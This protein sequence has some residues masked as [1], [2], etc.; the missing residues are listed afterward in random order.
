MG[1]Q[2]QY[3]LGKIKR[4]A[5]ASLLSTSWE[6]KAFYLKHD[7]SQEIDVRSDGIYLKYQKLLVPK[8]KFEFVLDAYP[9]LRSFAD[10]RDFSFQISDDKF[11]VYWRTLKLNPTT[12]E[13]VFIIQEIFLCGTYNH[14]PPTTGV[15]IDIGM[16]VGFASLFFAATQHVNAIYSFEPFK[17][18]FDQAQVNL[19]N[20]PEFSGKIKSFQFGLNDVSTQLEVAYDYS[21]K[22]QVGVYGTDLIRS[23]VKAAQKMIIELKPVAQT[24]QKIMSDHPQARFLLK[25][26]CE[27]SE[28][29]IFNSLTQERLLDRVDVIFIEWHE[30]GPE[31]LLTILADN[32]FKIFHQ[33]VSTKAIGMIYASR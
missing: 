2:L 30:R 33:R 22:G 20:N 5:Q 19:G 4:T 28:Y 8:G 24:F 1:G 27:G 13:E 18:T 10:Q 3:F 21:N 15:A 7:H 25:V 16:N 17:P 31:E 29:A 11:Y 23:Q 32:G 6:K 12:A 9:V 26:D 14:Y